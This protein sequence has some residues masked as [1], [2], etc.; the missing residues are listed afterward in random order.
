V[1][2]SNSARICTITLKLLSLVLVLN[3][4]INVQDVVRCSTKERDE[5]GDFFYLDSFHFLA[6]HFQHCLDVICFLFLLKRTR[7][8]EL[9]ESLRS[10]LL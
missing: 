4:A 8:N 5:F 2:L 9:A 6:S 10:Y 1:V 7:Q 3:C